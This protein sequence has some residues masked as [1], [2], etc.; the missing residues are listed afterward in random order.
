VK[1]VIIESALNMRIKNAQLKFFLCQKG[2]FATPL[3]TKK[4]FKLSIFYSSE[5][6]AFFGSWEEL[7]FLG[8]T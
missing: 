1:T 3:L 4:K 6:V 5:G 2:S 7:P 8:L